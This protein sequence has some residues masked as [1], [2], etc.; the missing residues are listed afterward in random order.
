MLDLQFIIQMGTIAL[1]AII[2]LALLLVLA[3]YLQYKKGALGKKKVDAALKKF[4]I[5]RN[6][7]VARDLRL[8]F[9]GR[10]A[11][12]DHMMIGFFGILFVSTVNDTAEYYGDIRDAQWIQVTEK[13]RVKM[14][15]LVEK[16][17]RNIDVVREIF[18]KN[19]IF[20]IRMD[21]IVVFCGR[22]KKSLLGITGVSQ[23]LMMYFNKFKPYIHKSK[24]EK[25]NNVDVPGLWELIMKYK[26]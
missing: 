5:I 10:E 23:S 20:N 8:S 25:D 7:R 6:Y 14:E 22:Q 19:S 15:N 3:R 12:I 2:L 24:F 18:A 11:H 1:C 21:G 16:N 9:N 4:G 26:A 13:S 17:M